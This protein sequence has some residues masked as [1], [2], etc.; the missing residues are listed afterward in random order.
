MTSFQVKKI[1]KRQHIMVKTWLQNGLTCHGVTSVGR[2]GL[3]SKF[4]DHLF[5]F[6]NTY[7]LF[8]QLHT[9]NYT[10]LTALCPGLPR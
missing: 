2:C 6:Q 5:G 1:Y 4:F 10:R 9:F 3:S 7:Q 8:V